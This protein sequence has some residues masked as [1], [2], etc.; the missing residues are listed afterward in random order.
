MPIRNS[1]WLLPEDG[2]TDEIAIEIAARGT[3]PVALTCT[4]RQMAAARILA[5]GGS[6]FLIGMRLR[7]NYAAACALVADLTGET[8]RGAA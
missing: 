1:R 5:S 6:T 4:E 8:K 3:R 2:I 7:M